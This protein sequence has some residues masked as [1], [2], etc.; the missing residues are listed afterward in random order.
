[1]YSIAVT[2]RFCDVEEDI[3]INTHLHKECEDKLLLWK[4]WNPIQRSGPYFAGMYV[5]HYLIKPYNIDLNNPDN[6]HWGVKQVLY[7]WI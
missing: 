3:F 4:K 7:E 1:M 5:A 2:C 6:W